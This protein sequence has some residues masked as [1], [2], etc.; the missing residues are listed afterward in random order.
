MTTA[1]KSGFLSTGGYCAAKL[2]MTNPYQ[3]PDAVSMA[4][5]YVA[6]RDGTTG[7]LYGAARATGTRTTWSG[8]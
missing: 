1:L 4:G 6:L 2:A 7:S 5:Y 8:G 3:F